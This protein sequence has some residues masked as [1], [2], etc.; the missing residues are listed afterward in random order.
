MTAMPSPCTCM[1]VLYYDQK[2]NYSAAVF[3][4]STDPG[5][6]WHGSVAARITLVG[7]F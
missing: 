3:Q 4:M 6:I 7:S 5:E 1:T 2:T